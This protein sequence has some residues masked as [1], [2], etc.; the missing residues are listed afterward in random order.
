L[1]AVKHHFDPNGIMNPG[2]T[3]GFE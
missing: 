3:L 2:G 1:R